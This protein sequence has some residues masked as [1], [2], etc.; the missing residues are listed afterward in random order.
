[1]ININYLLHILGT[2]KITDLVE[3]I[4]LP[5]IDI[6]L[7]IW[8]AVENG[9]VELDEIKGTIKALTTHIPTCD[10]ELADKLLAVVEYYAS[11]EINVTRGV[12]N[13]TVKD[14]VTGLGYKWHDYLTSLQWLIDNGKLEE[15]E[16]VVPE[17][18]KRPYHKFVFLGIPGNPNQE[19]NAREV[20]KWIANFSKSKVK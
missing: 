14:P 16:V 11:K 7:A 17:N 20:N 12:L 3:N 8:E 10:S 6:N 4:D 1:M 9:W 15:E 13:N 5:P 19:W 2:D 18:G